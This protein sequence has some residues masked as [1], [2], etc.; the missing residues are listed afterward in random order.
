MRKKQLK[1]WCKVARICVEGSDKTD[2][3]RRADITNLYMEGHNRKF[4]MTNYGEETDYI[5]VSCP[6]EH[7]D[8]WANSGGETVPMPKSEAMFISTIH[9]LIES[10]KDLM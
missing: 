9:D 1:H 7:F 4:R 3:S 2:W 8:R 10:S 6:L 5:Q